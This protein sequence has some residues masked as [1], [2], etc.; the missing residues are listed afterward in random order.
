MQDEIS[1]NVSDHVRTDSRIGQ[2]DAEDDLDDAA[3]DD[4]L[5]GSVE[6]EE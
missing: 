1:K 4:R 3:A 2:D 6:Y 5:G